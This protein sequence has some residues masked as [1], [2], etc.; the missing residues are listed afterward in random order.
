MSPLSKTLCNYTS[1]SISTQLT[2]G[3]E[4]QLSVLVQYQT[5]IPFPYRS[6][7]YKNRL[8][9]LLQ[10]YL[11]FSEEESKSCCFFP[12]PLLPSKRWPH[13]K[14][15]GDCTKNKQKQCLSS[16]FHC[17][18]LHPQSYHCSVCVCVC[19][20]VWWKVRGSDRLDRFWH[21]GNFAFFIT[22]G[23]FETGHWSWEKM[24]RIL[25]KYQQKK[26]CVV[27]S[28][29]SDIVSVCIHRF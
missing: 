21:S 11:I 25:L 4:L 18:N 2:G 7:L 20:C 23:H 12:R 16:G 6:Q 26:K 1:N 15:Q 13:Q 27:T 29:I 28:L 8:C 10:R 14:M 22:T 17:Q 19:V 9:S 5:V 3:A 24:S